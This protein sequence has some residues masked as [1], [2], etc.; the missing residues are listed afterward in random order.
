[1]YYTSR[2]IGQLNI[3]ADVDVRRSI[4]ADYPMNEGTGTTIYER[5]NSMNGTIIQGVTWSNDM[6]VFGGS[7]LI[8]VAHNS[9]LNLVGDRSF[10]CWIKFTDA[11]NKVIFEKNAND[12]FSIQ[13]FESS[14]I[15]HSPLYNS[16]SLPT[17]IVKTNIINNNIFHHVAFVINQANNIQKV[18][19]DGQLYQ[20]YTV[21][22]GT[23]SYGTNTPLYIG[24]RNKE[25]GMIGTLGDIRIYSTL[26]NNIEIATIYNY[27]KSRY[28]L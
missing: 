27:Q 28:G 2:L 12:G 22:G 18:Y 6:A 24:S 17:N 25:Y 21:T 8:T 15:I 26:L 23:P 13:Y 3:D 11:D 20:T 7:G 9:A 10:M 14:G 16:V 5:V 4:V 19:V 1:M